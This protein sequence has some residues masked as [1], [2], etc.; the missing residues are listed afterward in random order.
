MN[1]NSFGCLTPSAFIATL[2]TLIVI[3]GFAFADGN[4]IFSP[5][6]LNAEQGALIGA[7]TSHAQIDKD[8]AK[9]HAA[10]WDAN[11]MDGLCIQCHQEISTQVA[12]KN[13]MHGI[14][15]N[16]DTLACRDCHPEHRG[17]TA[18]L[19][20]LD[21]GGFPHQTTGFALASHQKRDAG[22]AF[23]CADCH[24]PDD[25]HF[26]PQRCSTCHEQ[27]NNT[28]MGIH[29][30][31][32]PAACLNCH[33]GLETFNKAYNHTLGGFPLQGKHIGLACESCH[34]GA[35][36]AADFHSAPQNCAACHQKDDAHQGSF[37]TE[38]GT[39]HT[40]SAW[41]PATFDHSLTGFKLD[42]QH[43]EAEC[44]ECHTNKT[45]KDTPSTCF[46]C[47]QKDDEHAGKYGQNC[48]NCHSTQGWKPATFDHNLSKFKLSGA[49][50]NVTCEKCHI[51][52]IFKGTPQT[53]AGCHNEPAFHA[54]LFRGQACE[55]CHNTNAWSPALFN[56]PHPQPLTDEGGSGIN[57]GN[58]TCRQCHPSNL[59][60][61]SCLACHDNN[62]PGDEGGEGG[63]DD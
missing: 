40:E 9:C 52:N 51:N 55:A 62:N 46:A 47:H 28:F 44:E 5:G 7:V 34:R 8:C 18:P 6:A 12:D 33:D 20:I 61:A 3:A 56:Q 43:T 36:T 41:K 29:S 57:H 26:D 31:V 48:Q 16:G 24:Q 22:L 50:A 49:H 17:A 63:G 21:I 2:L 10:P 13:S 11:N 53:C 23:T 45:F 14:M 38:C 4:N 19:T 30:Q 54:G 59:N 27:L 39:C 32:F 37:G 1:K 25:W 60:T 42:G 15:L 58:A 35:R